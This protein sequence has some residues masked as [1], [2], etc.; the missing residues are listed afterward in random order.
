M[1]EVDDSSKDVLIQTAFRCPK[2]LHKELKKI[3]LREDRDMQDIIMEEITKY[4]KLHGD[5]NP[6]Y[7]IEQWTDDSNMKAY[8]AFMRSREDWKSYI[9]SLKSEKELKEIKGQAQSILSYT[10]K[11]LKYGNTN[12]IV[13]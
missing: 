8:P 12:V 10:D 11:K 1:K 13:K 3:A 6:V 2:S 5:G 7:K 9:E 4:V